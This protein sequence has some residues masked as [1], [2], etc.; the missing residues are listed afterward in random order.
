[1]IYTKYAMERK[2]E[3]QSYIS[4]PISKAS[5]LMVAKINQKWPANSFL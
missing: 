3:S 1:M 4:L 5:I 2:E